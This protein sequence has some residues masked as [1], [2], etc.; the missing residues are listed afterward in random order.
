M[1]CPHCS[2]G[3]RPQWICVDLQI[4]G[5]DRWYLHH[6]ECPECSNI[7]MNISQ[8]DEDEFHRLIYDE[9]HDLSEPLLG[10]NRL[11]HPAS[12]IRPVPL[13]VP[14]DL[15]TDYTE[16]ARTLS[17]SPRVSAL[18][19]RCCL[20]H[21]L[22][23][24]LGCNPSDDLVSHIKTVRKSAKI[25]HSLADQL[26][27]LRTVGNYAAHPTKDKLTGTLLEVEPG[28]AEFALDVLDEMFENVFVVTAKRAARMKSI[29]EKAQAAGKKMDLQTPP[30]PPT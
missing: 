11:I 18:L 17:Y 8:I 4:S 26:E 19:S 6:Q 3:I 2:I 13:E 5:S 28:E 15:R 29:Q 9:G 16:A 1:I 20:E 30:P 25:S 10:Y 23:K 21:L 12:T 27:H 24:H 22:V 7:I 14:E